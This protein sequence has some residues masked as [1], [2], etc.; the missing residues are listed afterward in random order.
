[1]D[2]IVLGALGGGIAAALVTFFMVRQNEMQD[3]LSR[4]LAIQA[5]K[6]A[7]I[8]DGRGWEIE[9]LSKQK[10][11]PIGEP[12]G[13][14]LWF[15]KVEVRAVLD[16][17]QWN[18]SEYQ[19]YK[20]LDGR[21]TWIVRDCAES[22]IAYSGELAE[23]GRKGH[24]ALIS[25]RGFE[26]LATWIERATSDR[27]LWLLSSR[28]LDIIKPLICALYTKDRREAFGKR[29]TQKAHEF[30]ERQE[31][32]SVCRTEYSKKLR[33]KLYAIRDRLLQALRII[34]CR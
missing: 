34:A 17:F 4:M 1:M 30:L 12:S 18:P 2:G 28:G 32:K 14:G 13:G 3:L 24:P 8:L 23:K 33:K 19:F 5:C 7:Y 9:K 31:Q 6:E 11:V 29:L 15:R 22:R 26:E 21:R 10:D 16:D 25:S 27:T 20:F